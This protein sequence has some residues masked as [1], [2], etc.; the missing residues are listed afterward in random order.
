M[1]NIC[2]LSILSTI[3]TPHYYDYLIT[4]LALQLF[5]SLRMRS[6]TLRLVRSHFSMM[7]TPGSGSIPGFRKQ[8][9]AV[10]RESNAQ[11]NNSRLI[12]KTWVSI[13]VF[14]YF[15]VILAIQ[16]TFITFGTRT[17]D[18]PVFTVY[19]NL[20]YLNI[21]TPSISIAITPPHSAH[22]CC[23]PAIQMTKHIHYHNQSFVILYTCSTFTTNQS[24]ILDHSL[25]CHL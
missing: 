8:I 14:T 22:L 16:E 25:C 18:K 10:F 3:T 11:D 21:N 6:Q 2:V 9:A 4:T 23:K 19:A 17:N 12:E 24:S 5:N 15:S 7:C 1:Q 20:H 13:I